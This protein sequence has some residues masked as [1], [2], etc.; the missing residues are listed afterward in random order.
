MNTFNP[1]ILILT[2]G[3]NQNTSGGQITGGAVYGDLGKIYYNSQDHRY[4]FYDDVEE[5]W[6]SSSDEDLVLNV[7]YVGAQLNVTDTSIWS[8]F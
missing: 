8:V 3:Y 7:T 2:G 6:Y 4:Y 1:G 5:G